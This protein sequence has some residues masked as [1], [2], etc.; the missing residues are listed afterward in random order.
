MR[1]QIMYALGAFV[2]VVVLWK[3]IGPSSQPR[4]PITITGRTDA[5]AYNGVV[6]NCHFGYDVIKDSGYTE[7]GVYSVTVRC[8]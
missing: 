4:E 5:D 7:P 2:L 6:S 8:K 1:T 3:A